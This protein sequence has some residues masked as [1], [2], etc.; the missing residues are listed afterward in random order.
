MTD[1]K[2]NFFS[3]KPKFIPFEVEL[4]DGSVVNLRATKFTV[5]DQLRVADAAKALDEEGLS[6]LARI[7]K[8]N[9][10]LMQAGVRGEDGKHYWN[11]HEEVIECDFPTDFMVSV[12]GLIA[13]INNLNM[14]DVP[15]DKQEKKSE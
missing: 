3:V 11:S 7:Q 14:V 5:G 10:F 1:N 8:Y 13:E 6:S 2:K 9:A 4:D 12:V 15:E